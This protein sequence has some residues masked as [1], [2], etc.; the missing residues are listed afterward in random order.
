M[1]SGLGRQSDRGRGLC[2]R[3]LD[4]WFGSCVLFARCLALGWRCH[5]QRLFGFQRSPGILQ[6]VVG[7]W[8]GDGATVG[9]NQYRI[10][11]V[12]SN[13]DQCGVT[14]SLRN[15]LLLDRK[16]R[17]PKRSC[18]ETTQKSGTQ[19]RCPYLLAGHQ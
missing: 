5:H 4:L 9:S 13:A 3:V 7:T 19:T 18:E 12:D 6:S 8:R 17:Y 10:R 1:P 14:S 16:L 11:H 2:H 15:L